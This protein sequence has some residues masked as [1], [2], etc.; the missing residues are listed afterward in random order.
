MKVG[1]LALLRD[2][3]TVT[4]YTNKEIWRWCFHS[5]PLP[6][7]T[8]NH[9]VLSVNLAP[10]QPRKALE[11]PF[12]DDDVRTARTGANK[13]TTVIVDSEYVFDVDFDNYLFLVRPKSEDVLN[14][15]WGSI[16]L[17]KEHQRMIFVKGI[18]VEE[19]GRDDPPALHYGV[20]FSRA[21]LNRDRQ[22]LMTRGDVARTIAIMWNSLITGETE[23]EKIVGTYLQIMMQKEESL[24]TAMAGDLLSRRAA[25]KLLKQ[26]KDTHP[27]DAFFYFDQE[28]TASEVLHVLSLLSIWLF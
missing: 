12:L 16:L 27:E 5:Y 23:G 26:L 22:S 18:F 17:G 10:Y 9:D 8:W 19:R 25:E 7:G 1:I 28:A 21:A 4:Y 13:H 2:E 24:E 3:F 6:D 15:Q 20:D 14:T 11:D